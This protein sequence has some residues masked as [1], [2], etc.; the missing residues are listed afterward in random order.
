MLMRLSQPANAL[1][2]AGR[3]PDTG[4]FLFWASKSFEPTVDLLSSASFYL[5]L[6]TISADAAID[7]MTWISRRQF[8]LETLDYTPDPTVSSQLATSDVRA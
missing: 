4:V 1:I 8:A 2:R 3:P 6:V 5:L 7:P